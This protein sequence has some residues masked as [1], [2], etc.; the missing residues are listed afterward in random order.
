MILMA[1]S[2][3]TVAVTREAGTGDY[4]L[5]AGALVL[6][7]QG[8]KKKTKNEMCKSYA[9]CRQPHFL[10][11]PVSLPCLFN[12]LMTPPFAPCC[13][14][15][16]GVCCIDEFDKIGNQQQALLEA[17][18]QQTV[19]L[20]KAGIVSS[21]P[22]RTSVIA[23]ANPV[24]GHYNQ[25]KTV[26]ENLKWVGDTFAH[27]LQLLL[28]FFFYDWVTA[29]GWRCTSAL[30]NGL[31]SPVPIWRGLHPPGHTWR[32]ARSAAVRARH[33]EQDR[34]K[35]ERRRRQQE[36]RGFRDLCLTGALRRDAVWS[37]E[38]KRNKIQF[39]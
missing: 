16:A 23:A 21:L 7:D 36:Q 18:E 39:N 31:G 28:F 11:S 3:L 9:M 30:Q 13:L 29:G 26:S 38:S 19:S 6:A 1:F 35:P 5:E 37:L 22:A 10:S 32:V 34:R 8:I 24:G 14:H 12:L 2:G 15:T 17:M 20:A 4:A 27:T 33:G 25:G